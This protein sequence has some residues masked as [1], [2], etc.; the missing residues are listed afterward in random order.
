MDLS[1]GQ[2]FFNLKTKLAKQREIVAIPGMLP[3]IGEIQV[4]AYIKF[5]LY[6]SMQ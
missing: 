1:Q 2:L 4:F 3:W 5:I 6:N